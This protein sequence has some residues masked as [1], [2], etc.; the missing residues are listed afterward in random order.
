MRVAADARHAGQPEIKGRGGE[1]RPFK[2]GHEER[3]QAAVH[4]EANLVA[5][6]E[7]GDRGDVV[8]N[9]VGKIGC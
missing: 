1:S 5:R 7:L 3:A 9:P 2:E 6:S 8:D 4:M